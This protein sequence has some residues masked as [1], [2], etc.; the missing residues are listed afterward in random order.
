MSL[1][2]ILSFSLI[3]LSCTLTAC[4]STGGQVS[5]QKKQAPPAKVVIQT[6]KPN[7]VVTPKVKQKAEQ[8]I[9]K[10][11]ALSEKPK[12]EKKPKVKKAEEPDLT[13]VFDPLYKIAIVKSDLSEVSGA[14]VVEIQ[15]AL[16]GLGYNV[17]G[18]D[19]KAGKKTLGGINSFL[20]DFELPLDPRPTGLL[21]KQLRAVNDNSNGKSIVSIIET[22]QKALQK[23]GFSVGKIGIADAVT[24]QSILDYQLKN[25]LVVDGRLTNQLLKALKI[26]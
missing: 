14:S 24:R 3:G 16:N 19:G 11:T 23:L 8:S 18:A 26:K 5:T 10:E 1:N 17:G 13:S 2:K 9:A 7:L 25:N 12:V 20:E 22:V 15:K 21:I 4:I 6:E